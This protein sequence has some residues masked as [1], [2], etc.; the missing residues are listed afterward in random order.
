M[1]KN[2]P[3]SQLLSIRGALQ[4]F[5]LL[6]L[7]FSTAFKSFNFLL[8][9]VKGF[10]L[11][12]NIP[13]F[14]ICIVHGRLV[15][16]GASLLSGDIILCTK[17]R[18]H[19]CDI[20]L[21]LT[22]DISIS[23]KFFQQ[24][25]AMVGWH[26]HRSPGTETWK[27]CLAL[28]FR[29]FKLSCMTLQ[30]TFSFIIVPCCSLYKADLRVTQLLIYAF[31]IVSGQRRYHQY[32]GYSYATDNNAIRVRSWWIRNRRNCFVMFKSFKCTVF[33]IV[34]FSLS[35]PAF[36]SVYLWCIVKTRGNSLGYSLTS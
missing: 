9:S 7:P 14:V 27:S 26:L 19:S 3:R 33:A 32:H 35:L 29:V 17:H 20:G 13:R 28:Q 6:N 36:S 1:K 21:C 34:T 10:F 16:Y 15:P 22:P 2:L 8:F 23:S 30:K 25:D 11:I 18:I 12:E 31:L 24:Y 4:A 5:F